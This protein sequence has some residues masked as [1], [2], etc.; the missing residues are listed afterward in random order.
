MRRPIAGLA[1]T[2]ALTA[3]VPSAK[4]QQRDFYGREIPENVCSNLSFASE[5]EAN[6][7]LSRICEAADI[8][9]N[10]VM[11]ACPSI[12]NCQAV[13][14]AKSGTPYIL[15]DPAFVNRVR[16]FSFTNRDLPVGTT[17]WHPIAILAHE[18]GHHLCQHTTNRQLT[19]QLSLVNIEL[20]ADEYAGRIL[21]KLGA[22]LDQSISVMHTAVVSENGSMSHPGRAARIEAVTRGYREAERRYPRSGGGD[23]PNTPGAF[24]FNEPFSDNAREWPLVND[25]NWKT[26]IENGKLIFSV[27]NSNHNYFSGRSLGI[28]TER[29]FSCSVTVRWQQGNQDN[30]HGIIYCGDAASNSMNIFQVS[31]N[32]YYI[33]RNWYRR[34][35]WTDI[36]PWKRSDKV[37]QN[38]A[39][40]LLRVEKQGEQIRFSINGHVVETLPFDGGYGN[41][42]G[43]HV[44]SAKTVEFDNF[45]V[46]G[47]RKR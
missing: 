39:P 46:D 9:N 29:D 8:P 32:G 17:D 23:V 7:T 1:L 27:L 13:Y 6:R 31:A 2:L 24:L 20:Q 45:R 43:L 33:I 41:F 37:N 18:L 10:F 15:Y 44:V 16:G 19:S 21:Y 40:N 38:G 22:S 4:G 12:Q 47:T 28:D 11:A 3:G 30:G 26:S 25:P 5:D 35:A 14:D 42:F 36:V 34:G